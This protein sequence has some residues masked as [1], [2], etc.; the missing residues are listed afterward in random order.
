MN[1]DVTEATLR[2][3]VTGV[4]NMNGGRENAWK[5]EIH[6]MYTTTARDEMVVGRQDAMRMIHCL[7]SP[8]LTLPSKAAHALL[9][10][11]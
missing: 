8:S 10:L 6:T 1:P 5:R 9:P 4:T 11:V 2:M 7:G 3:A